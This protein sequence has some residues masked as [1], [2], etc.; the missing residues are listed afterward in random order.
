MKHRINKPWRRGAFTL[1]ELLVVIAIIGVLMAILVPALGR[2]KGAASRVACASNMRQVAL[3]TAN[4]A[5]NNHGFLPPPKNIKTG[6]V[7]SNCWSID[8]MKPL[9]DTKMLTTDKVRY[10]PT[11]PNGELFGGRAN[12]EYQPH[13]GTTVATGF[14]DTGSTTT[15]R[16]KKLGEHGKDRALLVDVIHSQPN[17]SHFDPKGNATWNVCY[18]D[19][20]VSPTSSKDVYNALAGRWGDKWT[21]LN[22]YIRVLELISQNKDPKIGPGKTWVWGQDRYYPIA[23]NM[24]QPY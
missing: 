5:Q 7:V 12:Y 1:V 17:V 16:W 23:E 4:Y 2:A 24:V 6:Y 22:D 18:P 9:F 8:N 15:V 10:C 20:H 11:G 3:A 21:R 19:G 14:S 13:P